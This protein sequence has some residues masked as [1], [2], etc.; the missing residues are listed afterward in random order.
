MLLGFYHS[1]K[2]T[3]SLLLVALNKGI[4]NPQN[5]SK[6]FLCFQDFFAD[7][8]FFQVKSVAD[9]RVYRSRERWWKSYFHITFR[10]ILSFV[11]VLGLCSM[12]H[13]STYTCQWSVMSITTITC[14]EGRKSQKMPRGKKWRFSRQSHLQIAIFHKISQPF[15]GHSF[16]TFRS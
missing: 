11:V 15:I 1:A 13:I 8:T 16:R 6:K 10:W 9:V 12:A 4:I 5:C 14:I 3:R 2:K 7:N